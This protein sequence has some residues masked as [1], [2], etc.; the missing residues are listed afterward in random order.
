MTEPRKC[1]YIPDDQFD[2]NGYIPSLVTEGEPGHAPLKGN[3]AH[4]SPW[5]WGKTYEEAMTVCV[6]ENE[7]LG[8][9]PE[10]AA[11]IVLSSM[12]ADDSGL[13]EPGDPI[14]AGLTGGMAGFVVGDCGHRVA[15]SERRAG[16]RNCERCGG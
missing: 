1:F 16:F 14:P 8:I 2:E 5:Y 4:A 6:K 12:N 3:G 13:L 7:R 9:S 10:D 15:A 11:R